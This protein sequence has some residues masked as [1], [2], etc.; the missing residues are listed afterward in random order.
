MNAIK[1]QTAP[2]GSTTE[3]RTS[4]KK[5]SRSVTIAALALMMLLAIGLSLAVFARTSLRLD[6]AQ[7]LF[8]TRRDL[9]GMLRLVAQD[10]HVPLYHVLLQFWQRLFGD[11]ILTA[12][13]LSLIFFVLT[14]PA[15]YRLASY[16][17]SRRV[18]LYAALLVTISPFMQWYGSEARMYAMLA[19]FTVVNQLFFLK[20]QRQG[21]FRQWTLYTLTATLGIYTHYF[22]SFVLITQALYFLWKRR[23]FTGRAL[24]LKFTLAATMVAAA[25]A[26]WIYYVYSEGAA[27]NTRPN[28]PTPSSGDLFNTYAQFIFG[29]QIDYVN[30]IIISLW[31]I[32]VLLAFFA[33][34]KNR[35]IPLSVPFFVAAAV[36]PVVGAFIISITLQPFYLSRY[37]IVSLPALLIFVS[38][39]LSEYPPRLRRPLQIGLVAIMAGLMLV[40]IISPNTPVKENYASAVSYLNQQAT[41]QDVVIASAPFTIYPIEYYYDGKAKVTTLPVWNRFSEGSIP[42]FNE[43][44]LPEDVDMVTKSYQR[45]F[46]ILSFDQ[47]NN[48]D[49]KDHFDSRYEQLASKK[50]SQGLNVY[51]YKLRYDDPLSITPI[52][53]VEE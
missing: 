49:I 30:T 19:F 42:P 17:F 31:P 35:V 18:G 25:I 37:L 4:S 9:P 6:E 24:F 23:S 28:L 40:Q 51:T 2:S 15:T 29:F 36:L 44:A 46:V 12:R 27:S 7:S 16:A 8:Q 34:Q 52:K 3:L 1:Q 47:G 38:W 33:L 41:A 20:V 48:K 21:T 11:S 10:V 13:L 39:V 53:A 43:A 26:P 5:L 22:F 50:F 14:I 45:A 32:I